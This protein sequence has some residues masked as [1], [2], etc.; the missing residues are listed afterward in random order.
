MKTAFFSFSLAT[1]LCLTSCSDDLTPTNNETTKGRSLKI[2]VCE[3]P[4]DAQTRVVYDHERTSFEEGDEIG[5]YAYSGT[6]C[7]ASNVRFTKE[8]DG[9]WTPD[10]D[11][12]YNSSYSYYAYFP[13]KSTVYNVG[14]SGDVDTRFAS[15]ISDA[16]NYFWAADQSSLASFTAANLMIAEGTLPVI[17]VVKFTM[18]HKRGL[19]NIGKEINEYYYSDASGTMYS[20]TPV[21]TG[22]IPYDNGESFLFLTKP[23]VSTT[24]GG[25]TESLTAGQAVGHATAWLT[26]TPTYTYSTST[27]QGSSWSSFSSTKPSW[28]TLAAITP[29]GEAT[30]FIVTTT[31][32]TSTT[33]SKGTVNGHASVAADA[34]LQAAEP[35]SN[36]DLSMVDNAGT[37]RASR[38]TANCYL[39][40][41]PGTYK[42]PLVYGNAIKN[43]STNTLAYQSNTSTNSY[44]RDNLV[45]HADANITDPWLKNNSATPDGAKIVWQDVK[46]MITDVAIGEGE[47]EDFLTFTVS[48]DNIAEGNAVIAATMGGTVVWSWHI[49]VTSQTLSNLTSIATGSHTYQVTPVNVGQVTG[50]IKVNATAYAG[51]LCRVRATANGVTVQFQVTAKDNIS[52]G[53]TYY[54][55]S[56]YYQWGRKDAEY[57]C[58]GAYNT[59]GTLVSTPSVVSGGYSIGTTIKNPEK[60]YYYSSNYGPYN[61]NKYN[62]WDINQTGTGNITT[63]TKK[64]VYD[65]CPPD[66]CVPTG[67]LYYYANNNS[68]QTAWQS[69]PPGR[70][71]TVGGVPVF[72]PAS[73]YRSLSYASLSHV[74]S[75]GYAWSA[76]AYDGNYGRYLYFG[77][78]SWG[79]SSNG[80]AYG[81][82]VRAVAEE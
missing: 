73:G 29:S 82:P 58:T 33:V 1:L 26:G 19:I 81:S 63:A 18:Q 32:S 37:A 61:E 64:T 72:F 50:T 51:D 34:I 2:E 79:W 16:S 10:I 80:R 5:L 12:P 65:P 62:Y 74:G 59:S 67:N 31:N 60:H 69:T 11:V 46:N 45:N 54:N 13:Y 21:F 15:F 56:P 68:G 6:T 38:T 49:W 36:V 23:S 8:E 57:P 27:N 71:W 28:L 55:P 78:S 30:T 47:D 44:K 66:F 52:G 4:A 76:S 53:T 35:V 75:Y 20:A 39:V 14:T 48:A 40:H 9:S 70:N 25:Y 43:G 41:A 3:E 77:S 42:L 24:V 7:V 17:G 22:N